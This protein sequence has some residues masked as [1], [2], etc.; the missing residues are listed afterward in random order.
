MESRV[1]R[2][3]DFAATPLPTRKC[4]EN[5]GKFVSESVVVAAKIRYPSGS[6]FKDR[7]KT[8]IPQSRRGAERTEW[9]ARFWEPYASQS[10]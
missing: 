7:T 9:S 2:F 10:F 6:F 1:S 4:R 8:D 5:C 3:A